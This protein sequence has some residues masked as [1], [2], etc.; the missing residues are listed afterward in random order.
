MGTI[1]RQRST[2]K[3]EEFLLFDTMTAFMKDKSKEEDVTQF[4]V[5]YEDDKW[6]VSYPSTE[7]VREPSPKK[8]KSRA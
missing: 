8:K 2:V 5:A 3:S 6:V 1:L 7:M 4:T